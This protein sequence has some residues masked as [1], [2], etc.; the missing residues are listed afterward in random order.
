MR[1]GGVKVLF[2][3]LKETE[4]DFIS[5]KSSNRHGREEALSIFGVN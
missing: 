3:L 1:S 2:I 5:S 4:E